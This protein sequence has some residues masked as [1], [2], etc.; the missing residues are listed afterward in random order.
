MCIFHIC[1]VSLLV[2]YFFLLYLQMFLV[3]K[4]VYIFVLVVTFILIPFK[5]APGLWFFYLNPPRLSRISPQYPL[6]PSI[7]HTTVSFYIF[8]LPS[9]SIFQ[10]NDFY[11]AIVCRKFLNQS[12]N[13]FPTFVLVLDIYLNIFKCLPSVLFLKYSQSLSGWMKLILQ[14]IPPKDR[15]W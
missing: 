13:L 1:Y 6:M 8:L 10:L 9:L 3:F 7:G 15:G 12:Y 14:Q 11:F 5:N 4:K 2:V